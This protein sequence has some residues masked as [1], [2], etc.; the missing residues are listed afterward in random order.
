[1]PSYYFKGIFAVPMKN[2]VEEYYEAAMSFSRG[3]PFENLQE[4]HFVD[5]N[6]SM[7]IA[8]QEIFQ[9]KKTLI[10]TLDTSGNHG[11]EKERPADGAKYSSQSVKPDS[12]SY[13]IVHVSEHFQVKIHL[14]K[15]TVVPAH[16]I[17]CP[18]DEYLSS[19]DD[20]AVQI[21][22]KLSCEPRYSNKKLNHGE[23]SSQSLH[24]NSPWKLIIHAVNPRYD[25]NY[26]KDP[27]EFGRVL[28]TMVQKIIEAADGANICSVAIPLLGAS[29]VL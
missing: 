15:V 5:R 18:Q 21:F 20:I 4:I 2:C 24:G 26:A 29:I 25:S 3:Y 10:C 1:M 11:K 22:K 7:V 14:G 28:D 13:T 9:P 6:E 19:K 17:V 27:L 16:A 12:N 23:I 8:M